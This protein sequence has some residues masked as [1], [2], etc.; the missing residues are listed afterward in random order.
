M[1]SFLAFSSSSRLIRSSSVLPASDFSSMSGRFTRFYSF[2]DT[3]LSFS[4]SVLF[5]YIFL[6]LLRYISRS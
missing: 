4:F 1:I 6:S 5:L 3:S 2:E